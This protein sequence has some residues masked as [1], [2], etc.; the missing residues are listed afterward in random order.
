MQIHQSSGT[1][2]KI[3][4]SVFLDGRTIRWVFKVVVL[5]CCQWRFTIL[6]PLFHQLFSTTGQE[7]NR[8]D[9]NQECIPSAKTI[10]L[11]FFKRSVLSSYESQNRF[12]VFN[13]EFKGV[14]TLKRWIQIPYTTYP[15]TKHM[16]ALCV[17]KALTSIFSLSSPYDKEKQSQEGHNFQ[18]QHILL[19][20]QKLRFSS[21]LWF[22][23]I[24]QS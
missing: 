20:S 16:Q 9:Q 23:F 22:S 15:T 10:A 18:E 3:L 7:N 1:R 8:T 21:W 6:T 2:L 17:L 5:W 12:V 13:T 11:I 24:A 14:F 4:K 19:R